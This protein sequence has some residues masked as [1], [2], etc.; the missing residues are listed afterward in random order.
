MSV[1]AAEEGALRRGAQAVNDAK[2]GID[3][4]VKTVRNEID[5]V[6]GYWSGAASGAFTQLMASWDAETVKLNNVL[7]TLEQS[8]RGTDKDQNVTEESHQ[9]TIKGLSNMMGS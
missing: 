9:Q 2:S 4:Q 1:I 6:R 7:I 8:L 5:Q 3:Q